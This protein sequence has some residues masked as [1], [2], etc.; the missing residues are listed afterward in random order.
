MM[1]KLFT[2]ILCMLL[3]LLFLGTSVAASANLPRVT[4]DPTDETVPVNG[5]CQFVTR[6]ENAELAEWHF[7][8]PD[9][10][11]DLVYTDAQK[12]FPT[13][14]IINGYAKDMT[15]D[16]IPVAL[17]GWQV[18]CRFTNSSG[19]ADSGFARITVLGAQGNNTPSEADPFGTTDYLS[20]YRDVLLNYRMV[21]EDKIEGT[22]FEEL[23]IS[24]L[25][26]NFYRQQPLEKLGYSL[27]DLNNDGIPELVFGTVDD[28]ALYG[29]ILFDV[30]RLFPALGHWGP[31]VKIAES[32]FFDR[33][34]D[35]GEGFLLNESYGDTT[36][37]S[38]TVWRIDRNQPQPVFVEG[39]LYQS[40]I[41]ESDLWFS[42]RLDNDEIVPDHPLKDQ[43]AM[44]WL[45]QYIY[46]KTKLDF[47][48]F[49]VPTI[50][51]QSAPENTTP[52]APPLALN[53]PSPP[54]SL[55]TQKPVQGQ[56]PISPTYIER[57]YVP[58]IEVTPAPGLPVI[59]TS[60]PTDETLVVGGGILFTADAYNAV[61]VSWDFTDPDGNLY[62][63]LYDVEDMHP[64]IILKSY[65]GALEI[66]NV[67]LSINGWAVQARFFGDYNYAIS[68]PA[69]ITV[70]EDIN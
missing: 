22:Q 16:N 43:E 36:N 11:W 28:D 57:T 24:F 34:F 66:S 17:N 42:A 70:L 27:S 39:L 46:R 10:R 65:P 38:W 45:A 53:F 69:I 35:I 26:Y 40:T 56:K 31:P 54:P 47:T 8:S 60:Y 59:I 29:K 61:S 25:V 12:L 5:K 7:V 1:K 51:S 9:G 58:P 20:A 3:C 55:P 19:S 64:G 33:W 52:S 6:Y 41:G 13:L 4:K 18:Y 68:P 62:Q 50:S 15:L 30:Y 2:V 67:P 21:L 48:P 23:R 37:Q 44:E 63:S 49:V 14:T 32:N